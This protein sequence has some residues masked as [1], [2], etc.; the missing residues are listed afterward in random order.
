MKK[1]MSIFADQDTHG[2]IKTWKDFIQ[3]GAYRNSMGLFLNNKAIGAGS[4]E[5]ENRSKKWVHTERMALGKS[6]RRKGHGVHLYEFMIAEAIKIGATRIY[7]SARLNKFSRRM[8]KEK[9]ARIYEVKTVVHRRYCDRC[10]S[11]CKKV[12]RYYISL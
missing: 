1:Y 4:L 10:R 2:G 7:S 9:L 3:V 6:Y 11:R 12:E 5:I 8:W